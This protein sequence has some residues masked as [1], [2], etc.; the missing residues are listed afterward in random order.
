M[1]GK[2]IVVGFS[3]KLTAL[4]PLSALRYIALADSSA[5]RSHGNC[6]GISRSGSAAHHSSIIQSLYARRLARPT[7]GSFIWANR[8]PPN[9]H[10]IEGKHKDAQAPTLSMSSKRW[11]GSV[12]PGRKSVNMD[13][14][15]FHS[16][17][18]RP[19]A[20]LTAAIG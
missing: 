2:P 20:P 17:I 1:E 9:P 10:V 6:D 4:N 3:E 11:W 15:P 5:P 19:T 14:A 12:T 18:G 13:A 8:R 7:S 16:E